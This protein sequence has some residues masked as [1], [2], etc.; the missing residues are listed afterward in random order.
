M[1]EQ[2]REVDS[3]HV[4]EEAF[5]SFS[6]AS[7]DMLAGQMITPCGIPDQCFNLR[8][9]LDSLVHGLIDRAILESLSSATFGE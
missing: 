1:D 8:G 2:E 6:E 9:N 3:I 4:T 5:E 7:V